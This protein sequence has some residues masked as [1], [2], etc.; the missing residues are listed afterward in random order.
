MLDCSASPGL[1]IRYIA[2]GSSGR[3]MLLNRNDNEGDKVWEQ[4][5]MQDLILIIPSIFY[6]GNGNFWQLDQP[7]PDSEITGA[8]GLLFR[9]V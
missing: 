1:I 6:T 4:Y 9:K 5:W 7:A 3:K 2:G 8:F